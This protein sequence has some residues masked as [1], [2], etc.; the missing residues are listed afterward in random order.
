MLMQGCVTA[1]F[2]L[3]TPIQVSVEEFHT[4]SKMEKKHKRDKLLC[5]EGY[6]EG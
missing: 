2:P 6:K 3:K 1:P 4:K 5:T